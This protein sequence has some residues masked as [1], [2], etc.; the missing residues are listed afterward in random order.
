MRQRL[1]LGQGNA[2]TSVHCFTAIPLRRRTPVIAHRTDQHR[3]R[4][5]GVSVA[6]PLELPKN[7]LGRILF[8]QSIDSGFG[9]SQLGE[10]F[11]DKQRGIL[12]SFFDLF[13]CTCQDILFGL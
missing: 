10:P 2:S 3:G 1:P 8:F 11:P 4:I 12:F 13:I 9:H 6:K 5:P 7:T